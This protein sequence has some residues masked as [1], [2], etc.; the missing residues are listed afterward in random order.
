MKTLIAI[1]V[2]AMTT[3]C[4]TIV[5]DRLQP[6]S[7]TSPEP[8][9]F[10]VTGKE[11]RT[12]EGFTPAMLTLDSAV[13]AFE[14]ETYRVTSGDSLQT[15]DTGIQGWFWFGAIMSLTSMIVDLSTGNMCKLP[16]EVVL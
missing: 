4:S 7:F 14:C 6:V 8:V 12:V 1:A 10:T 5:N 9:A 16:E 11:G 15:V 2:I 13:G 3:G